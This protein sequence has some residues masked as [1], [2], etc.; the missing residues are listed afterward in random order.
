MADINE[1]EKKVNAAK[2]WNQCFHNLKLSNIPDL[3]HKDRLF[4][5]NQS[6]FCLLSG[7]ISPSEIRE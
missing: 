7:K 4:Q 2:T 6:I 5:F 1:G 3:F